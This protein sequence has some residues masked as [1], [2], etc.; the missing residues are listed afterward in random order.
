MLSKQNTWFNIIDSAS[1]ALWEILSKLILYFAV[2]VAQFR[3]KLRHA[4]VSFIKKGD[5]L[6]SFR[7]SAHLFDPKMHYRVKNLSLG[8]NLR[9][10]NPV[11]RF[12]PY[13]SKN[14][15]NIRTYPPLNASCPT[16]SLS[17]WLVYPFRNSRFFNAK[18]HVPNP[19][20]WVVPK[21]PSETETLY[22][23]S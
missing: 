3:N 18:S 6:K 16:W 11:Q 10:L 15:F 5:L 13:S 7:N 22:D 8:T 4:S 20:A 2:P 1:T 9:Q 12:S 19:F 14:R 17:L 21:N 23:I